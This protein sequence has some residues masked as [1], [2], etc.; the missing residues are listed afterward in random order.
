M[1]LTEPKKLEIQDSPIPSFGKDE[2]SD[3]GESMWY[4]RE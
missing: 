2:V 3:S 1:M 4:L